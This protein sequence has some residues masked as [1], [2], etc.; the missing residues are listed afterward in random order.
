MST[1]GVGIGYGALVRIGRGETPA[2]TPLVGVGD[3]DLPAGEADEVDVT[4]HSS[5]NRTKEYVAGL[6]DNGSLSIPLDYVPESDQDTLLRVL[7]RTG[8][9]IQIE[10]TA[11]GATT[12][13]VYAGFVR[14]YG[15]TAPV[16]G[17]SMATLTLRINGIV[18][19]DAVD[20]G[21]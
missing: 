7:H 17:K 5:P 1:T 15:R 4:S 6:R 10:I 8:E 3:F 16:Q 18:S 14:T 2:W 21:V 11:V 19:G 12:P 13:E 9:L 20:P